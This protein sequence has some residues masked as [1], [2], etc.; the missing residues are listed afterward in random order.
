MNLKSLRVLDGDFITHAD[1][2]TRLRGE[3]GQF[4]RTIQPII[5]P[6]RVWVNPDHIVETA[7]MLMR[8]YRLQ[9]LPVYESGQVLGIVEAERLLGVAPETPVRELM[10]TDLI[11]VKPQTPLRVVAEWMQ[12]HR[13]AVLPV[14][15]GEQLIG[16]ITVYDLLSEIGRSYDPMTGLPWSDYLREWSIERL[17]EGNEI[18]IIFFDLDNFGM[19][20]K[21]YGHLIGDEVLR[22]VAQLL[23]SEIDPQ[24]DIVCRWGGDEFAIAT[25][26]RREEAGLLA[27]HLSRQ[28]AAIQLPD[29]D[30][31]IAVSYGYQ[32]G[33]RTREREQ[34]HYAAT[35]DNLVNLASQECLMMKG[36]APRTLQGGQLALPIQAVVET[37]PPT[38]K[39]IRIQ[40]VSYERE[41]R[42]AKARVYLQVENRVLEGAS[43]G[44]AQSQR[45]IAE[46]TLNALRPLMPPSAQVNLLQ[47]F[48]NTGETGR[49]F[50][51]V[52][53]LWENGESRQELAGIALLRE[54]P[55]RAI[56]AAVLDALNRPL[57]RMLNNV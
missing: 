28:I 25:L 5:Q 1:C 2:V 6:V 52:I 55:N 22:R 15:E 37:P 27:H 7:L 21:R 50:V 23:Q 54:D 39:R 41:G 10:T 8:G 17:A 3:H 38:E 45:L 42:R 44:E 53:L 16:V 26:R 12:R 19:F 36:V 32:G 43:E 30:I 46:A 14:M 29:I 47:V 56:A 51:S 11:V 13:Q 31:P 57:G 9:G 48:E 20:N 4:M 33:K 24:S 40:S 18:T 34:V 35:V 49:A